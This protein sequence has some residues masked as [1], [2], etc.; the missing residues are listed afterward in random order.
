[1]EQLTAEI[2][3]L[4]VEFEHKEKQLHFNRFQQVINDK[5]LSINRFKHN[6]AQFKFYTG[7]DL[8]D[9]FRAVLDFLE[10]GASSLIYKSYP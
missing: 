7:F 8:Y 1:M 3:K 2:Q 6:Q 9:L 10:P 4:T 5:K